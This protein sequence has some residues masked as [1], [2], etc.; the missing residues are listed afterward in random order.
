MIGAGTTGE[1]HEAVDIE[2]GQMFVVKKIRLVHAYHGLDQSKR[3]AVKKEIEG[4]CKLD[5]PNIVR[6]LG[7]EIIENNIFCIYLEY[8]AGKSIV[9]QIITQH[10]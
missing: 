7:C 4:Y 2:T 6:Y 8:M 10:G 1:V 3:K 9:E 5:H